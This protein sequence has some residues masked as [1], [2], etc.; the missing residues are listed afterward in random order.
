MDNKPKLRALIY[1]RTSGEESEEEN[2][3]YIQN[4]DCVK[5]VSLRSCRRSLEESLK[6]LGFHIN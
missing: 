6:T 3:L 2:S 4:T 5:L 1:V